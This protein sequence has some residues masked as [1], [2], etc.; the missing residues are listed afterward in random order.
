MPHYFWYQFTSQPGCPAE[1]AIT[2][3]VVA[4]NDA[5]HWDSSR[6]NHS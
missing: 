3:A 6:C 2:T 5:K 1:R 4:V